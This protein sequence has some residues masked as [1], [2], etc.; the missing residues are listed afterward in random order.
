M[1]P[2]GLIIIAGALLLPL[3]WLPGIGAGRDMA[4]LFSQYLG[5]AAL[6]AM[7]IS[8][9][10]ATRWPGIEAAFGPLDQSYRIHKWLGIGAM[11]AILVH[12]TID[13]DM[14]GLGAETALNDF[15]ETAGEVS[16]Y[17]LLALV[18]I[19][20]IT[21]I[22]YHLW[23]F[24]HCL[25][26][27][28]FVLGAFHYLFIL[29]PSANGD[30][31]GIYMAAICGIGL[32]AY[33]YTSAPRAL[34][35]AKTY[36]IDQLSP[37]GN[38]LAVAM[39]P[40]GGKFRHRAGQFGFFSFTGAGLHEPHPFT[41][42]SAPKDDGVLQITVAP[43]GDL[44]STVIKS[45]QTG[46]PVR[47][48]GPF[49]HFG[50]PIQGPQIWIA[51]GVGVTPFLALAQALPKDAAPVTMIFT[52]RNKAEAPHLA[53][54]QAIAAAQPNFTLVLWE[55]ASEGRLTQEQ[56]AKLTSDTIRDATVRFC[57]PSAMRRA[58]AK[59]L[60]RHGVTAKKFHYEE[61]E[62]RTGIGFRQLI[63]ALFQRRK[64]T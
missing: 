25:I 17:G 52:V 33:L 46:Q 44:T 9:L 26:G 1:K 3:F 56:I 10:I 53:E 11:V 58:L 42:S 14:R 41:I 19:T 35:P 59:G 32:L 8:Q 61:F 40:M 13:A 18:V 20:L 6:I 64:N 16:L 57:G 31:L 34:R 50:A 45:L 37:Q 28:F 62:I 24:T 4:A 43:L 30:P 54:L 60:G 39:S 38:A 48:E 12:D 49:G 15:A 21:F 2:F 5:L 51:A 63:S 22:P 29:K 27:V 47:V 55:S 7:A 23:K 36:R